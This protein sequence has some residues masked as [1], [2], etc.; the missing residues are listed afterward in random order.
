MKIRKPTFYAIPHTASVD[1][2]K[3]RPSGVQREPVYQFTRYATNPSPSRGPAA[4]SADCPATG[5]CSHSGCG[6]VSLSHAVVTDA[7]VAREAMA[8]GRATAAMPQATSSP[9]SAAAS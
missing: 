4:A 7:A 8:A 5:R 3:A 2:F 1:D 9:P 6:E